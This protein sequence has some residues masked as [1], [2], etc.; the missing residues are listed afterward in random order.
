MNDPFNEM[1]IFAS[2]AEKGS[3]T[4]AAKSLGRSK[5]FVS[6]Q[7][8]KLEE[9]LGTQ[10]LFRTTRKLS[11]TE[12]GKVYLDYCQDIVKSAT[13]ARQS[14]AAL[15][16]EMEG[17]ICISATSSFGEIIVSDIL[18]SFQEKYPD[19]QIDLD[20]SDDI[21]DLKENGI[22]LSIRGGTVVDD[23]LVAIPIVTWQMFTVGTT[24]YL[25]EYGAPKTPNDLKAHNCIGT[26]HETTVLGWPYIIDGQ[27][28]RIKVAGDFTVNRNP[29][30]KQTALQGKGLAWVPSYVV[31]QEIMSGQLVRVLSDYDPPAFTFYLV[32]VY[33]KA[34]PFRQRCLID[35][36]KNWFTE[37]GT[38]GLH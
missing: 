20:L 36:I 26:K 12:A 7:L 35:F 2:I 1:A 23:E 9:I 28:Q 11:L 30:I 37:H 19:V 29:L 17:S 31:H 13:A 16:G 25:E 32:Y 34:M 6:Q 14:I 18:F 27:I 21:Q 24:S 8:T 3:F 10:L 15:Q 5:A 4:A 33:Q 22:D 38:L